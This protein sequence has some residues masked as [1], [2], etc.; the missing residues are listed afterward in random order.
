[1]VGFGFATFLFCVGD[2]VLCCP[3]LI[4][5]DFMLNIGLNIVKLNLQPDRGVLYLIVER[6]F[7]D[8]NIKEKNLSRLQ[9]R[10]LYLLSIPMV[11]R[12]RMASEYDIFLPWPNVFLL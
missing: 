7:L 10:S 1:M 2:F 4:L 12:L 6:L 9:C 8:L 11:L 5:D 3:F